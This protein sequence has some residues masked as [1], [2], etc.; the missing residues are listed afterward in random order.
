MVATIKPNNSDT[1]EDGLIFTRTINTSLYNL[2]AQQ[3][4][5]NIL[6]AFLAKHFSSNI[7]HTARLLM[8][9][10]FFFYIFAM[11]GFYVGI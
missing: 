5:L 7:I 2:E 11:N 9:D 1:K 8:R 4:K 6:L 3:S 10:V